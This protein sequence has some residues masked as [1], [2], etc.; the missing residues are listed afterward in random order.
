[1]FTKTEM[2]YFAERRDNLVSSIEDNSIIIVPS[3][4]EVL[5]NG[6]AN[7][8]FRQE[9]NFYYLTGFCE[10]DSLAL[11]IKENNN[12]KFIL[13]VRPRDPEKEQWDGIRAGLDGAC[14]EYCA[15][16]SYDIQQIDEKIPEYLQN[17]SKVYYDLGCNDNYDQKVITWLNQ[18][19]NMQRKGISAPEEVSNLGS[20]L[21]EMRLKKDELEIF[22]MQ[23]ASKIAAASHIKAMQA[24]TK[25][26]Y[27]YELEAELMYECAKHGA[28]SQ[29]Y[30]PIV[31]SGGNTCIL[32]Y[33]ENNQKLDQNG[34]VLIDAGAEFNH[35]AAD[36]T[37]TFP[38]SGKFSEEQK[39]IYELVLRAQL[40][41]IDEVRPGN[42]WDRMQ[43]TIL[44]VLV[45]GLVELGILKPNGASVSELIESESYKPFYMHNSG[46]WLGLDV[47][48]VG[49]YKVDG[50]W[51]E[52]EPGMALTIEPGIYI[53]AG[54]KGVDPKWWNIGV[55]IEDDILVTKSGHEVLTKDVPKQIHDIELLIA[56]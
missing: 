23:K 43:A 45:A 14:S 11:I 20:I 12:S 42:T 40:A 13:F 36:I 29:A 41:A 53:K 19:K 22:Y 46:H 52:L 17:K 26:E 3:N 24:V 30:T 39:K 37:R 47:H 31:G 7:Y 16:E 10:P 34:L 6:D 18:V 35:Y 32:H 56:G 33:G 51:R 8:R 55:R 2:E 1:M 5:R 50:K 44:E 38:V 21:A 54:L 9:S 27:E 48:D 4:T 25:S 15:Y 49:S 28:L